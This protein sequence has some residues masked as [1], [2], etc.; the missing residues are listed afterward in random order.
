MQL[1]NKQ[2]KLISFMSKYPQTTFTSITL[3]Q[4]LNISKRTVKNY[5]LQINES[6]GYNLINSSKN[7]YIISIKNPNSVI[8]SEIPS[9]YDERSMYYI[10]EITINRTKKANINDISEEIFVSPSTVRADINKMNYEYMPFGINFLIKKD[11]IIIEG[12]EK[13]IRRLIR[14]IVSK[15]IDQNFIDSSSVIDSFP[16][17][18]VLLLEDIITEIT[19]ECKIQI[20][21][22]AYINFLLHVAIILD[23]IETGY[24]ILYAESNI[25]L[26]EYENY[27]FEKFLSAIE[28]NYNINLN[29]SEKIELKEII[30]SSI[31][32]NIGN[33]GETILENTKPE[34][35]CVAR[36]AIDRIEKNYGFNYNKEEF[37][38]PFISHLKRL[39]YRSIRNSYLSNPMT[40]KLKLAYPVIYEMAVA[41]ADIIDEL[42]KANLPEDEIGLLCLHLG[43]QIERESKEINKINAVLLVPNYMDIQE[44]LSRKIQ[45][46]YANEI[47]LKLVTDLLQKTKD[48]DFELLITTF[49]IEDPKRY[50]TV[51]ITPFF[52]KEDKILI[53]NVID[54][55]TLCRKNNILFENFDYYFE[56]DCFFINNE[57]STREK[58][59]HQ[60]SVNV[61]N[62]GY[63]NEDFEQKVL[64]RE[65]LAST[66]MGIAAIP[67]SIENNAFKSSISVLI[68]NT[69]II[70]GDNIAKIILLITT[71]NTDQTK[72]HELYEALIPIFT[73]EE[74][75]NKL[76]TVSSFRQF[77]SIIL[78]LVKQ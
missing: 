45:F 21:D 6:Y 2:K 20:Y 29:K 39:Y 22:F 51:Q 48:I 3:S 16:N 26:N 60:L 31:C 73:N 17:I 52:N 78:D 55:L 53:N 25:E 42:W 5:I 61:M 23:R 57:I 44:S 77:K 35:L 50:K 8:T 41:I 62:L 54:D 34:I 19:K 30:K 49:N 40:E 38:M 69:G 65:S 76:L 1:N 12:K 74:N 67:H 9:N 37:L 58:T 14:Y 68:N 70:W 32:F 11:E 10:K 63:V 75:I 24:S 71:S 13:N 33:K 46:C 4:Y 66:S 27:F 43:A 15:E 56:K 18:N 47:N 36:D 64:K 72:F 28:N 59:I 7:G